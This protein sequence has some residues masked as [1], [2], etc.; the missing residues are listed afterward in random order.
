VVALAT[1]LHSCGHETS[2]WPQIYQQDPE[3][4][5]TYHFLGTSSTITDFHIHDGLLFHLGHLCVTVSEREK[6]IWEAHYGRVA[7]NFGIE[8]NVVILQRHF[9]SPKLWKDVNKY[10]RSYTACAISKS[11]IKKQG[12]YTPLPILDKPWC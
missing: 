9:Y 6:M 7:G 2:E 10:I 4:S 11:S 8:K 3:L 5:T 1:V 12:L